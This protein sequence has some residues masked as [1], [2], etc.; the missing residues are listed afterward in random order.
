MKET[1][2][3]VVIKEVNKAPR[4]E[5]IENT[6]KALQT[7]C[8]GYIQMVPY[9]GDISIVCNEEGKIH[10][11]PPNFM[12]RRDVIVGNTLFSACNDDGEQR[13]LTDFEADYVIKAFE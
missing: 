2:I 8:G 13:S 11:M 7:V 12:W 6:L 1:E 9:I 3:R 4:V 10:G 5:T